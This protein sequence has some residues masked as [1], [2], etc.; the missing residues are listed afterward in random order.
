MHFFGHEEINLLEAAQDGKLEFI[1]QQLASLASKSL[2]EACKK[3]DYYGR[4]AL[5]YAAYRGHYEVVEY[6]L[7]LQCLDLN[8]TDKQG[9]S[10]LM[11]VCVRGYNQDFDESVEQS[12]HADCDFRKYKIAKMLLQ[13]GASLQNYLKDHIN[14]PLHWACYFGD[15]K[16]AQLLLYYNPELMLRKNDRHQF[17]IDIALT[18]G[19]DPERQKQVVKYLIVKFLAHFLN[20]EQQIIQLQELNKDLDFGDR[21]I[22]SDSNHNCQKMDRK[23][24][25]SV[26]LNYLFWASVLGDEDLVIPFLKQQFSAFAPS[27]KGRNAVHAATYQGHEKLVHLF[28]EQSYSENKKIQSKKLVNLMTIEKPQTALHIAVEQRHENIVNYLI[29][30]GADHNIYNFR[31]QAAFA[32]SRST[33]IKELRQTLLQTE[34]NL[35]R[36][37]YKYVLVGTNMSANLVKQQL[38]NI[39]EKVTVGKFKAVPLKSY[40]ESC[41]YYIIKVQ[42]QLKNEVAHKEKMMIYNFTHGI[43]C[44]FNKNK[45]YMYENFHHYHDQQIILTLLYDEF[46]LDQFMHDQLLLDHFPL[47]DEEEKKLLYN[48]W[49]CEK[50]DLLKEPLSFDQNRCRTPSAIKAYFGSEGGFFFVFLSFF[51]TWLFLPAIPGIMLGVY[52]YSTNRFDTLFVP[53]Y[54]I[55]LAV[56]ATIFFE[57]WKRKQSETM[58]QFDMH[59]ET[60]HKKKIQSFQGQFWIDDVTHKIE[61]QYSKRDKWKYYKTSFPLVLLAVIMIAGEQIAYQ[62]IISLQQRTTNQTIICSIGLGICIKITNEIFNYFAK[63]SMKYENHQYQ[64]ELEDAYIIKVF[65]FSF[66][67]SFVRLFYKSIIDPDADELNIMSITLTIVWAIVHLTRFTIIPLIKHQIRSYFL[68]TEYEQYMLKKWKKTFVSQVASV[69]DNNTENQVNKSFDRSS[70]SGKRFLKTVEQNRIMMPTP[71]HIDQFTYFIIQFCMV[72]MFSASSQL[73]PVAILLFNIFTIDS[74]LYAYIT[75]VKRPIAEAKRSIGLWNDIL[76]IVGYIGT[77]INCLTIY[78]ANQDQLNNLIGGQD[79]QTNKETFALR[80]FLLLIAA[81]HIVIGLK[82]LIEQVIPDEPVWV[83]KM[84]QRQE[85]L[86]EQMLNKIYDSSESSQKSKHD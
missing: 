76:L 23:I 31:N 29:K 35:I 20:S 33:R 12:D 39:K 64:N 70:M 46:N 41:I 65:S 66:L 79:S 26:G 40:N 24:Y 72:T 83:T 58:F 53:I 14:N 62:Y 1:Q 59:V 84:M 9:N 32:S 7:N 82:F 81:E 47:H 17:P 60:E 16:L 69:L 2:Q 85:Y 71:N 54:T 77:V 38:N 10:A 28:F 75:F 22:I 11:L 42:S 3:S 18:N 56:W 43:I 67:N 13:R 68:N 49:K 48:Q 4:N 74:L 27:Y 34:K 25:E 55:A 30:L 6:F 8:S 61:I 44:P 5:H 63:L 57:F 21:D 80:N 45:A 50:W 78:Q 73:I 86:Y 52:I 37:G 19:K 51:T 15:L 36:S